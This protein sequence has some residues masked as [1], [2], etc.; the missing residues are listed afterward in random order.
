MA[1]IL[2]PHLKLYLEDLIA[3]LAHLHFLRRDIRDTLLTAVVFVF[4]AFTRK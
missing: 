2:E 4:V 1:A 3:K